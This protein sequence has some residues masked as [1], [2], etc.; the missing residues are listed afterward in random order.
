MFLSGCTSYWSWTVIWLFL[1]PAFPLGIPG[2]LKRF[3]FQTASR[4][5]H[6]SKVLLLEMFCSKLQS[7][8]VIFM[9]SSFLRLYFIYLCNFH[10][11]FF[12]ELW[13][14][15]FKV[16]IFLVMAGDTFEMCFAVSELSGFTLEFTGV[17][18]AISGRSHLFLGPLGL[19]D[20]W[21]LGSSV[22]LQTG[23][24]SCLCSCQSLFF[25]VSGH[26]LVCLHFGGRAKST[27][28]EISKGRW[29]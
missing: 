20:R 1:G 16:D 11:F 4:S 2:I 8:D 25:D 6:F 17:A 9:S 22:L 28:L 10:H 15:L 13:N 19:S 27:E 5:L 21:P 14:F 26:Y 12:L 29:L 18:R 24:F 7:G 3:L 23:H